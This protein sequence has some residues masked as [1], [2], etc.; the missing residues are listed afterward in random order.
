MIYLRPFSESLYRAIDYY[1]SIH[2]K[3][4]ARFTDELESALLTIGKFPKIGHV[5]PKYRAFALKNFPYS[6]CY[7]Q[8]LEGFLYGLVLFHHKQKEPYFG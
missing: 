5:H 6:I 2:P 3:V 7:Y 1:K 8:D 4:A